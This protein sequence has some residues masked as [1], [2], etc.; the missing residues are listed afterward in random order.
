MLESISCV[1]RL[2]TAASS[3]CSVEQPAFR[4]SVKGVLSDLL[5]TFETC[6]K[7]HEDAMGN[8]APQSDSTNYVDDDHPPSALDILRHS[9]L[10]TVV[11]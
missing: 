5:G 8:T 6:A 2:F 9:Y 1:F 7:R 4:T 11:E 3:V 10:F